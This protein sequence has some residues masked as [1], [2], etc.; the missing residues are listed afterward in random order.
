MAMKPPLCNK[1]T[2]AQ[3]LIRVRLRALYELECGFSGMRS[4][5]RLKVL[6]ADMA[7]KSSL[8]AKN[9]F[10]LR[11]LVDRPTLADDS[12]HSRNMRS[13]GRSRQ[14]GQAGETLQLVR[15]DRRHRPFN[16][17]QISGLD[18]VAAAVGENQPTQ[19]NGHND[20]QNYR[21]NV[22]VIIC[23]THDEPPGV[24]RLLNA[25]SL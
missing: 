2:A 22:V 16:G 24:C 4:A 12:V 20:R 17:V 14:R 13:F 8:F 10:F 3:V 21:A 19:Q 5:P 15:H 18:E 11:S 7:A 9:S 6:A 25:L 23:K 1:I